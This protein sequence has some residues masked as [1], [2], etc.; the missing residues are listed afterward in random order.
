MAWGSINVP[1]SGS[2]TMSSAGMPPATGATVGDT[3][4]NSEGKIFYI[5]TSVDD[6]GNATWTPI[7]A[8]NAADLKFG[9]SEDTLGDIIEALDKK[10]ITA[11]SSELQAGSIV[12]TLPAAVTQGSIICFKAPC[13]SEDMTV[14]LVIENVQYPLHNQ[15]GESLAGVSGLFIEDAM[16]A[17]IIDR[18]GVVAY[19]LSASSAK[20]FVTYYGSPPEH[21]MNGVLYGQIL[22]DFE[23]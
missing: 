8:E 14:G 19:L 3:W 4:Y 12:L 11:L 15:L 21:R 17:V 22:A 23:E 13:D 7:G 10:A 5:C 1:D 18:G 2:T 20:G 6:E 9:D 16:V